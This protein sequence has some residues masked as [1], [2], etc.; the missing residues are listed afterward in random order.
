[1]LS[2]CIPVF[3]MD[4]RLLVRELSG[5][6]LE[7]GR[8]V[9]IWVVDDRSSSH[10]R[11]LNREVERI[12][13]VRYHE[14][15]ANIGRSA[16]RNY[17]A[18]VARYP[19]ILFL[20]ANSMPSDRNFLS[21]YLSFLH[22]GDVIC[23]GT[24]Y[25]ELPPSSEVLLRWIYG[26]KREQLTVAQRNSRGFAISAK[27]FI[28]QRELMLRHPFREDIR[29][30]GHEDTVFGYDVFKAGCTIVHIDNPVYHT[31]LEES[32]V[33]LEK[34]RSALSNLHFIAV[35]LIPDPD[36]QNHS[37]I[38]LT[39]QSLQKMGLLP[40]SRWLFRK[41]SACSERHLVGRSPILWIFDLYRLGYFC[42]L[43][44]PEL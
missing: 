29:D 11:E 13:L 12:P 17:L 15:P 28:I 34:T 27:N 31:G 40:F 2:V 14:L 30:Y 18:K 8:Q 22:T 10:F 26:R 43:N 44:Q 37:R 42:T 4:I 36:F 35:Y 21:N 16:I 32:A 9:E 25:P 39:R 1:M 5:Q 23:G 3:N 19:Y 41:T 6:A 7:A 38:F 24:I 33:Y 20:D